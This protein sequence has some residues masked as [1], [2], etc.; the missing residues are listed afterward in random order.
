VVFFPLGIVYVLSGIA[1]E[2]TNWVRSTQTEKQ[3]QEELGSVK[4]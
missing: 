3:T 2:A 1:R 4:N